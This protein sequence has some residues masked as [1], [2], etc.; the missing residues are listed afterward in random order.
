MRRPRLYTP[1]EPAVE[2][3][4]DELVGEEMDEGEEPQLEG[5]ISVE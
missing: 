2:E 3:A 4:G 5:L 1:A